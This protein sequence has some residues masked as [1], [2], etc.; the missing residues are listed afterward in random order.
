MVPGINQTDSEL[1]SGSGALTDMLLA[2]LK[3]LWSGQGSACVR[4]E[5]RGRDGKIKKE[6]VASNGKITAEC[7]NR[8]LLF[9]MHRNIYLINV[10]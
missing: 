9:C 1:P 8:F 7:C 4:G 2:R 6:L 5:G 3:A 10:L